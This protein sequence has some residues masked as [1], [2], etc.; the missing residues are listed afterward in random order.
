[1]VMDPCAANQNNRQPKGESRKPVKIL[2]KSRDLHLEPALRCM[3][4]KDLSRSCHPPL[5]NLNLPSAVFN[6]N[7]QMHS[8]VSFIGI[9][10]K[11]IVFAEEKTWVA[12][13][14]VLVRWFDYAKNIQNMNS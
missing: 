2:R 5:L 12:R 7:L 14:L 13:G 4:I 3:K 10:P 9:V 8:R 1:M 6:F 11:N